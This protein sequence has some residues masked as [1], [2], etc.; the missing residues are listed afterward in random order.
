M[1]VRAAQL[2]L[3][4]TNRVRGVFFSERNL[5]WEAY[6]PVPIRLLRLP[7]TQIG[8]AGTKEKPGPGL[9]VLSS[10]GI[11]LSGELS[12]DPGTVNN[13]LALV[14]SSNRWGQQRGLITILP[15]W[16]EKG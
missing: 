14:V 1:P 8:L 15:F 11:G 5:T 9:S 2:S 10:T 3:A 4:S 6:G 7:W 16:R 12:L 13:R